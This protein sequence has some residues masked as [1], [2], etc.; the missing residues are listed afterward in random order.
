MASQHLEAYVDAL[1]SQILNFYETQPVLDLNRLEI[2]H[3]D[4]TNLRHKFHVFKD[5][6][7]WSRANPLRCITCCK[8]CKVPQQDF[9]AGLFHLGRS[10]VQPEEVEAIKKHLQAF[11]PK[12][13]VTQIKVD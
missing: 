12:L 4:S 2:G 10:K 9:H 6:A 11:R 3:S 13:L 1:I 7:E 8:E 5:A